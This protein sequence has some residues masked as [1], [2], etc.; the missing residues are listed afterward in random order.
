MGLHAEIL[1]L[2]DKLGITYKDASHRLYMTAF[3]KVR[4]EDRATK[5]FDTLAKRT[6][7]GLTNVQNKLADLAAR[8]TGSNG[9]V[10]EGGSGSG[11]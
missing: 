8:S 2:R 7:A 3:E 1:A 10:S 9:D 4:T 11:Q 6:R 5:A